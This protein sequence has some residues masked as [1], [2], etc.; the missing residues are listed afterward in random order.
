M[1]RLPRRGQPRP[2]APRERRAGAVRGVV[3]AVR[4]VPRREVPRL[5]RRR[6]RPPR[7]GSGTAR[8]AVPA[9]R[10]LPQP[11]PAALQ[12]AGAETG[13]ATAD[14]TAVEADGRG[15][16]CGRPTADR[17]RDTAGSS[18]SVAAAAAAGLAA[19]RLRPAAAARDAARAAARSR[20]GAGSA[21][22]RQKYGKAV[23]RVGR[24]ARCRACC[25][26]TRS[27]SRAAS[28]AGAASYA[29]VEE[30]NQS[31]DPQVQWIRVLAMDKEQGRSTSPTPIRT[32]SRSRCP[33][34][35]T[36]TCRSP[37]Q[38]C[39]NPPCMKVCPT[40][41]T[42]TEQD[43]IVV[44]DYDW[45]IGCR[46]CMAACPYGAR[47][48]N[49][50]DADDPGR[51][52]STRPCTT[53]ATGRGRGASSRS[54]RSASSASRAGRYPACVEACPVGARKFGNL[55]DPDSE[56]RYIIEHKRVLRAQGGAEHDAEVLLLLRNVR[57]PVTI[58]RAF[59]D[60][61]RP[62]ACAAR[63]R[64]A[65][66]LYWAWLALLAGADRV[67]RRWP[68][69]T[70][71]STGLVRDRDARPGELGL[72][73]RQLHVPGRRRGGG[74]GA[75]HPGLR[76][77]LE[78]DPRDRDLRR[79]AGR[80]RDHHV[81]AVRAGGH[82]PAGPALAHDP[83]DRL[84]QLP[85]LDPGVGRD[86]AERL[87]RRQLRRRDPHPLSRVPRPALRRSASSCRWCCCRSR[88]RSASTP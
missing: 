21:S 56:I 17:T 68:T 11:A 54:A 69:S 8:K 50:G 12:A 62:A 64:A 14:A 57:A 22:T 47:H 48:F 77:P 83:A 55:L 38:Q 73:H 67:G 7:S 61:R 58:M 44:I 82:R 66:A 72:L 29:C 84:P 59:V 10:A 30:N 78:A 85:A 1:P 5:A 31:R 26:P 40:G 51:A 37:C 39:R 33:R 87:L 16:P 36:S 32:T 60:V 35:A 86:R 45:C 53:W 46:C 65:T 13:A 88:W 34:P 79:A 81:P 15:S 27:T 80:Q 20:S 76:L 42:W 9:L 63:R 23:T 71:S 75:R 6:A 3:S 28:A 43:G 52:S 25:S 41:A 19:D 70:R 74:G 18:R 49:W 4:P 2:A 24:R